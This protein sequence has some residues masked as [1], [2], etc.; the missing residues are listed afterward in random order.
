MGRRRRRGKEEEEEEEAEI[1][2]ANKREIGGGL[3]EAGIDII[4]IKGI[5]ELFHC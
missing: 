3:K 4:V 5:D 1:E 2:R